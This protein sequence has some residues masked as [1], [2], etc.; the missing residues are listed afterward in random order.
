MT[1][2]RLCVPP[3]EAMLGVS[4]HPSLESRHSYAFL[5]SFAKSWRD[6][7][8]VVQRWHPKGNYR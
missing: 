1:C 3:L 2:Q 5:T 6:M 4:S 8:M 7:A